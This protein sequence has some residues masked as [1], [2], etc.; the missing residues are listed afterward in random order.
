[1]VLSTIF[2]V[3]MGWQTLAS[4]CREMS[5]RIGSLYVRGNAY[6]AALDAAMIVPRRAISSE[7]AVS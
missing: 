4:S 3:P 6:V 1:M 7:G 5:V 2:D